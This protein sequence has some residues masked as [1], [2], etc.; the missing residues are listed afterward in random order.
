MNWYIGQ[1]IVALRTHSNRVFKEGDTFTIRG[2][3]KCE[4]IK[5]GDYIILDIGLGRHPQA[6]QTIQCADRH[7]IPYLC[8]GTI[9]M[10]EISFKPLDE[11]ADISELVEV[12]ETESPFSVRE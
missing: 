5:C 11:L 2:I 6:G 8:D 9:W 12:L 1:D 7:G 3:K 4:C 10:S